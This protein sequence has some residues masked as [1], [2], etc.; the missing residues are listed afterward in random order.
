MVMCI[1]R[2]LHLSRCDKGE[3]TGA[4]ILKER[5]MNITEKA[6]MAGPF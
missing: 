4:G 5:Q 1:M 3:S 6:K 2:D